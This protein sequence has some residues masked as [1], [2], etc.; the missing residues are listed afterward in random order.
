MATV[1][2]EE[3]RVLVEAVSKKSNEEENRI[4]ST[5]GLHR[6]VVRKPGGDGFDVWQVGRPCPDPFGR[7]KPPPKKMIDGAPKLEERRDFYEGRVVAMFRRDGGNVRLRQRA[8]EPGK[9]DDGIEW[10]D[11]ATP[12]YVEVYVAPWGLRVPEQSTD[13]WFLSPHMR[14]VKI[15]IPASRIEEEAEL[16]DYTSL[17]E[18]L[19]GEGE[20]L[21]E[22][23]AAPAAQASASAPS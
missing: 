21:E 20:S 13:D 6:I 19:E 9:P 10:E 22:E 16:S 5:G 8:P 7:D 14:G 4:L 17:L 18:E 3:V 23:E 15:R 12:S 2:R 11:S 1:T